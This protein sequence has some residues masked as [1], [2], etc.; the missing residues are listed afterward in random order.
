MGKKLGE[1][2]DAEHHTLKSAEGTLKMLLA[3]PPTKIKKP[4]SKSEFYEQLTILRNY[5]VDLG[6]KVYYMFPR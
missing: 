5:F 6:K 1:M 4:I 3:Q 2:V